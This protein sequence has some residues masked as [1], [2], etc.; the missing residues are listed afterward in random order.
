MF[1]M[2]GT[3]MLFGDARET[4]EGERFD[5]R[6]ARV[7][8]PTAIAADASVCPRSHQEGPR[9]ARRVFVS[10]RTD[11]GL[12]APPPPTRAQISQVA[13]EV[14]GEHGGRRAADARRISDTVYEC[15]VERKRGPRTRNIVCTH[16]KH[17]C[18]HL[19]NAHVECILVLIISMHIPATS[20][21]TH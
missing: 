3:K 2:P 16:I 12:G 18:Y 13:C 14:Y 8:V 15:R 7:P 4:C 5:P 10:T 21:A 6:A 17:H 19:H 20:G 11:S 1:F 9:G